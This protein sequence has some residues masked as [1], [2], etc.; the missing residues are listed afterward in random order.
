M[1]DVGYILTGDDGTITGW[2]KDFKEAAADATPGN[3]IYEITQCWE[4]VQP[5]VRTRKKNFKS[6]FE[7]E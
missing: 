1:K 4:A 7:T 5:S 3:E 6:L 2:Y